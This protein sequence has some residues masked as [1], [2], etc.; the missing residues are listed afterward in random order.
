MSMA[1]AWASHS[2][3][4]SWAMSESVCSLSSGGGA[5]T[6]RQL[7]PLEMSDQSSSCSAGMHRHAAEVEDFAET[8]GLV[9]AGVGLC[10]EARPVKSHEH[11]GL[12]YRQGPVQSGCA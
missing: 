5:S 8:D 4:Y 9:R 7:H 6:A 1:A 2:T 11:A 12:L 3:L 10:K